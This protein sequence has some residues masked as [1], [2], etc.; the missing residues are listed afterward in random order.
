M[1]YLSLFREIDTMGMP[2]KDFLSVGD[3][4]LHILINHL[5]LD[6]AMFSP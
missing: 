4:L 2:M 5:E 3:S 1:K 6:R